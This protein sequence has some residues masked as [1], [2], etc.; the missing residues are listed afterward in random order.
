FQETI[1]TVETVGFAQAY[2][3]QYSARP[4]TPAAA[5]P[6]QIDEAVKAGR[7]ARLQALLSAQQAA[8]N[9]GL[10]GRTVDV[11]WEGPG[12]KKGQLAGRTPHLQAVHAESSLAL[13]GRISAVEIVSASQN[14]LH[15]VIKH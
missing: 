7:L 8:F 14:S 1:K 2:S 9:Q 4:G 5:R 11:L 10:V 15:G 3:F 12:R 13:Q 6:G